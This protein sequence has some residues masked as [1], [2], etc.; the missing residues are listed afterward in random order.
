MGLITQAGSH[1]QAHGLKWL[2][3]ALAT[4]TKTSRNGCIQL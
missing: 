4:V 2:N 1:D 3:T